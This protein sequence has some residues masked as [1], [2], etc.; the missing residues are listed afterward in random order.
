M[1]ANIANLIDATSGIAHTALAGVGSMAIEPTEQQTTP[2]SQK[3]F[4]KLSPDISFIN[5]SGKQE[6]AYYSLIQGHKITRRNTR[7]RIYFIHSVVDV[8]TNDAASLRR[9]IYQKQHSEI[10]A[11]ESYEGVK[12]HGV[13]FSET[14]P[15]AVPQSP[16]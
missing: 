6:G 12:I 11:G 15:N 3:N 5:A 16:Y 10:K 9:L 4:A 1:N 8:D 13:T 14:A 2:H 7:I